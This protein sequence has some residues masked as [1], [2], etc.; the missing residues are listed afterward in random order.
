MEYSE[1]CHINYNQIKNS[2]SYGIKLFR[3]QYNHIYN[4]NLI[5][6]NGTTSSYNKNHCQ[7]SDNTGLNFWNTSTEGNYW[8]DWTSPDNDSN[9]IVDF[10]YYFDGGKAARDYYPIADWAKI[11][12]SPPP[13]L[14]LVLLIIL[15]IV[16]AVRRRISL[17]LTEI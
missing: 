4:N 16:V 12:E 3:T 6:N 5:F 13:A 11:P 1:K 17:Y 14:A 9:G 10:P 8:S 15:P 7:A 2:T